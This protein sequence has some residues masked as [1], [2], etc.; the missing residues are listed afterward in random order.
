MLKNL[1]GQLQ[2]I[3]RTLML[4]VAVLPV[5]GLMFGIGNAGLPFN[6]AELSKV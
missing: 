6:P 5:A 3:G 1:F 2:M 4:P